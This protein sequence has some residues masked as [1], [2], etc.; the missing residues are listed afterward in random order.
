MVEV[1]PTLPSADPDF[2]RRVLDHAPACL[3]VVDPSGR[4]V[5]ANRAMLVLAGR[6]AVG[7]IG[8]D[9]LEYVHPDDRAWAAEA[10]SEVMAAPE[11]AEL[12]DERPWAPVQLRFVRSDG[13]SVPV[14]V[15]GHGGV[16][17]IGGVIYDVR[18][19]RTE[20][21]LGAVLRGIASGRPVEELLTK[22]MEMIVVSPIE[23][24]AA[25]LQSYDDGRFRVVATTDTAL[26]A[27]LGHDGPAPWSTPTSEPVTERVER[28]SGPFGAWL[29]SEGFVDLW[30]AAVRSVIGT[31]TYRIVVASRSRHS[32]S[33]G[34]VARLRRARELAGVI[35]MRAQT[36][37]ALA[38]AASHDSLTGL[39]NRA[40]FHERADQLRTGPVVA[41]Y[42]DLD[43]FKVI[44]D[45]H[46]HSAGDRVLSVIADR[47]LAAT[48]PAD[49]VARLGGD[50]FV[51]VL[52]PDGVR[53]PA[54]RGRATAERICELVGEA[55]DL[56]DDTLVGV[57]ASVGVTVADPDADLDDV[58]DA[59]DAAMYSAK[60]AGGNGHVLR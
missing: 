30:Y 52:S 40:G 16:R 45:R 34:I 11:T 8:A 41:L 53:D 42:V 50:E 27:A 43:G 58:L 48:R 38:H 36:D 17:E 29:A 5:Y 25:V 26:A 21:L 23:L 19:A 14:L 39:P 33:N 6:S 32:T 57:S 49:L 47:L 51:V 37:E 2:A 54:E 55:V 46:G 24:S 15:T 4:I 60:R 22:V 1:V 9:I 20:E 28:L 12:D 31:S 59:A 10:F 3:V 13:A 7:V 18:V 35:L 44:N 56:G